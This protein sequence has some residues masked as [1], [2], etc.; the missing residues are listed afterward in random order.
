MKQWIITGLILTSCVS[1]DSTR[2]FYNRG[3]VI[4][5]DQL[6]PLFTYTDWGDRQYYVRFITVGGYDTIKVWTQ[7]EWKEGQIVR[8]K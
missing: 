8:L 6:A 5:H 7:D 3:E 1:T 4:R 2:A